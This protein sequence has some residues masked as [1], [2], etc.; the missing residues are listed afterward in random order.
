MICGYIIDIFFALE[1]LINFNSA[2]I[3][4]H[5][6]I[7]DERKEIC[8]EYLKGWF[9]VDLISIIPLDIFLKALAPVEDNVS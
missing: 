3:D 9:F 7:V 5:G 8:K 1:I 2:I 6:D 4:K